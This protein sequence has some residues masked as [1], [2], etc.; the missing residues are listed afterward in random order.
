MTVKALHPHRELIYRQL[1]CIAVQ[2]V[3]VASLHSRRSEVKLRRRKSERNNFVKNV[4]YNRLDGASGLKVK[5][6]V[7]LQYRSYGR[8]DSRQYLLKLFSSVEF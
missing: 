8:I 4:Q 1:K 7:F 5:V 3:S 6:V 2:A